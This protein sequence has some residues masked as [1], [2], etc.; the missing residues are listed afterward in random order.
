[1]PL[2]FNTMPQRLFASAFLLLCSVVAPTQNFVPA[3]E[4]TGAAARDNIDALGR[5]DAAVVRKPTSAGVIGSPYVDNRWLL[6]RLTVSTKGPLAPVPVKYDVLNRRLLMRPLH[7]GGDS[8]QLDDR[9]VTRFELEEPLVGTTTTRCRVFRR[10]EEA[11]VPSQ[12]TDYVE[13]M[14]EGPTRCLNGM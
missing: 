10:F 12:R 6:A 5:G 11:P 1:M 7:R 4:Q 13:V 2:V 14:H 3:A 9:S 8:L